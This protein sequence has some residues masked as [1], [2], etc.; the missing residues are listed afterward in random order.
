MKFKANSKYLAIVAGVLTISIVAASIVMT[1]SILNRLLLEDARTDGMGWAQSVADKTENIEALLSD[2][3]SK[4]VTE[5]ILGR[6]SAVGN[7]YSF[8]FISPDG[9]LMFQTGSYHPP[10]EAGDAEHHAHIHEVPSGSQTPVT[11]SWASTSLSHNDD[12]SG[13]HAH[14]EHEQ[15]APRSWGP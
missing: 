7:I 1:Q 9:K 8:E 2:N 10:S 12:N 6:L 15:S 11:A 5:H 3:P 14:G 4:P 13:N